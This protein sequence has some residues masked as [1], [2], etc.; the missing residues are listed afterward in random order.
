M[1]NNDDLEKQ[2]I[3]HID[4]NLRILAG[5][6]TGKTRVLTKKLIY[7]INEIKVKPSEIVALTFTRASAKELRM[8][9]RDRIPGIEEKLRISTLHSFCLRQLLR[10]SKVLDRFSKIFRIA[11]DWEE[12][13]IIQEDIK[14]ITGVKSVKQ[15][16]EQF[17]LLS[18]DWQS[19][20]EEP[21]DPKFIGAWQ[22]HREIYGYIL[23]DE[24]VYQLKKALEQ[25]ESVD[26]EA[27][28]RYLLVDE[29]QD[30]NH[31]D[32]AII[33]ELFNKN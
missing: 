30:L 18:A 7:L 28:I 27:P 10:N 25:N 31:C 13:N 17:H 21:R 22:E 24:I 1:K 23:R 4:S 20:S 26:L 3:E 16:Q 9:V 14:K 19:L 6:G 5:P 15:I 8:R 33:H 12:R 2:A 32:Q 11:D 29:Y